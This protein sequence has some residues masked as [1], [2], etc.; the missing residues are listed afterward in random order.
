[1]KSCLDS[2][3][4]AS[5]VR[6]VQDVNQEVGDDLGKV[7]EFNNPKHMMKRNLLKAEDDKVLCHAQNFLD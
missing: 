3:K 6:F 4:Q 1:M 5:V 2:L 7:I